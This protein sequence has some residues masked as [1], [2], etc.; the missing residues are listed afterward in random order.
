MTQEQNAQMTNANDTIIPQVSEQDL[1]DITGGC[2]SCGIVAT[3][4]TVGT[5]HEASQW[6][7]KLLTDDADAADKHL[8]KGMNFFGIAHQSWKNAWNGERT[9]RPCPECKLSAGLVLANTFLGPG[10]RKTG[11]QTNSQHGGLK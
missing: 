10:A 8:Q 2:L 5:L 7:T 6:Q 9:Y 3:A 4:A 11:S 1:Q